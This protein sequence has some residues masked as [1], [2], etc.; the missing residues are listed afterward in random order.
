MEQGKIHLYYGDGKGKTTAA[1]G[2]ALRAAGSGKRVVIVQFLKD[3]TSHEVQL[4]EKIAN[5]QVLSGKVCAAFVFHMT[6]QQ[7]KDTAI[8]HTKNLQKALQLPCDVLI[9]DEICASVAQHVIDENL[10][11][12]LVCEKPAALELVLTGREPAD[13]MLQQADYATQMMARKHPY[14]KGTP[15]RMGIEF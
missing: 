11:K 3:G 12:T 9:L 15:A 14:E 4:L 6:E 7:K 13:Y 2:L 1:M 5:I 8:L 10:V